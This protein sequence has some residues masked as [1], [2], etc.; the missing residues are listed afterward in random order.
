MRLFGQLGGFRLFRFFRRPLD[1]QGL[2]T[3]LPGLS[4]RVLGEPDLE[5]HCLLPELDLQRAKVAAAFARGDFC[6][7][8]LEG[9]RLVGYCWFAFSPA[10]HLDGVWVDFHGQGVW[11]YKSLV[12]PSHRGRG[13]APALYRIT[14]GLCLDRGRTFSI[15]CIESH[16]R[17][18]ISAIRRTGYESAGYGGYLCRGGKLWPFS[19][20]P[21]RRMSVRFYIPGAATEAVQV[22]VSRP[23]I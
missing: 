4:V 22:R 6:A 20:A 15:S 17:S 14:D 21:V 9:G 7:G 16:N 12:L 11:M 3:S 8:A 5:Q 10:P 13:I 23:G 2:T 1:R 19:S 18:S